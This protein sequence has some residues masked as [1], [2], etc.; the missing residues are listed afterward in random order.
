MSAIVR[1]RAYHPMI[2]LSLSLAQNFS[3]PTTKR[4]YFNTWFPSDFSS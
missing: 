1:D 2:V 4:E 3:S